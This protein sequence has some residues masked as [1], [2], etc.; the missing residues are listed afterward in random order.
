[1]KK[2]Q[3]TITVVLF[4]VVGVIIYLGFFRTSKD[5]LAYCE[6]YPIMSEQYQWDAFLKSEGGST[7]ASSGFNELL[8]QFISET[9]SYGEKELGC[10]PSLSS[11]R[12]RLRLD[13]LESDVNKFKTYISQHEAVEA[14]RYISIEEYEREL[15]KFFEENYEEEGFDSKE[16]YIDYNDNLFDTL[17]DD[18]LLF[19]DVTDGGTLTVRV[20]NISEYYD[21]EDFILLSKF[22][23]LIE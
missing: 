10:E 8:E 2:K 1:M 17:V 13:V 18:G 20:K 6:D 15:D 12:L 3:L 9:E 23:E 22:H 16:D 19:G 4:A 14:I 7:P 5:V 21:V 11:I